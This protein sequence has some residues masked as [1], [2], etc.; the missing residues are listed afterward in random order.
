[1]NKITGCLVLCAVLFL[2][3]R[4][5]AGSFL[6]WIGYQAQ[7]HNLRVYVTLDKPVDF[8]QRMEGDKLVVTILDVRSTSSNH[9]RGVDTSHFSVPVLR[10][11]PKPTWAR[12]SEGV[13]RRGIELWVTFR[14]NISPHAEIKLRTEDVGKF[15]LD[16]QF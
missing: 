7:D 10:V 3:P 13:K 16:M 6:T 1:M 12:D 2:A 15:V 4:S 9:L 14:E 5:Q 8:L 11:E